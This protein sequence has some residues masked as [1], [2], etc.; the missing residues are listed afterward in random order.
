MK[1]TICKITFFLDTMVV[2]LSTFTKNIVVKKNIMKFEPGD[3]I[4][5][6]ATAEE[7]KV[8]RIMDKNMVM[9]QVN[10]T[11]FPVYATEIEHPYFNWF[12]N[13]KYAAPAAKKVFVDNVP[14]E[15]PNPVNTRAG[16]GMQLLFLPVYKNILDEDII[17]KVKIIISNHQ[18]QSY[19][20]QYQFADKTGETFSIQSEVGAFAEFYVHDITYEQLA[21]NPYFFISCAEIISNIASTI[22]Q[23]QEEITIKP[24][25][26]FAIISYMHQ[27]NNPFFSQFLF[28][29][30][31]NPIVMPEI[32]VTP[33]SPPKQSVLPPKQ[34]VFS[35]EKQILPV[36]KTKGAE[37]V[38]ISTSILWNEKFVL[39]L[40]IEKLVENSI[41]LST[42]EM[43]VLQLE[44][45]QKAL[46]NAIVANVKRL[47][48][49][50]GVGKGSLKFQ[51]HGILNQTKGVHSYVNEYSKTF[52]FGA[53]EIFFG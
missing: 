33:Y 40:H 30:S 51:I 41:E 37:K 31:P 29:A 45:F 35:V 26:L 46:D 42:A 2:I 20:F 53:T 4:A 7:G 21:T 39:D 19:S 24:K 11:E 6:K 8:V 50:H 1:K 34:Q 13:K 28:N 10:N 38:Q 32:V 25:K 14:K 16:A 23:Y 48:I 15:K 3:T 18:P 9:I 36:P 27:K 43:V 22:F 47:T 12:V 52:G 17:E 49:I 5:I 44:T